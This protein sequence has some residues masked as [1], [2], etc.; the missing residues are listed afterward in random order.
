MPSLLIKNGRIVD[1]ASGLDKTSDLWVRDGK[2][3]AIGPS[4]SAEKPD[5]AID[6]SGLIV[7]PGFIDIHVHL[8]EPG[9]EHKETIATGCAAALAGGFISIACMANTKPVND[10]PDITRFI[11]EKARETNGARVFPIA[12][13]TLGLKGKTLSPMAALKE[14]GTVAFSDDGMAVMD[15]DLLRRALEEAKRLGVPIISHCEMKELHP[16]GVM[17]EGAVSQRLGL[18]GIPRESE[19]RMVERDIRLA[20]ETGSHLHIAHISTGGAVELVR[21]AKR[22]GLRVTCEAA[23]HHFTLT[24]EA[25][26]ER[27]ADAKMSPPLRSQSDMEA[28]REGLAD[29][30]IDAIATDHAPHTA[31]EK[32]AGLEMAPFGIVGL[33]TALPLV[34]NLARDK[35]IDLSR[36]VAL[37]STGPAAILGLTGGRLLKGAEADITLFD[38][39]EEWIV[40]PATFQSK[41]RNTPFV[42]WKMR[43]RPRFV[44]V[45]G[46]ILLD[47]SKTKT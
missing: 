29:G 9:F 39:E 46:K 45:G 18:K 2:I 1:P 14:A 22:E 41:G 4:L 17:H 40:D 37:L 27:K 26:E 3:A 35:T 34:M 13:V 33:E 10:S 7:S 19:D 23:P 44:L 30:T 36:A 25:V 47:G 21:K 43:G 28:V 24:E 38:P 31:E 42:G 6:A 11:L 12:A 8:R 16:G 5:M 15:E 32:A 20:R